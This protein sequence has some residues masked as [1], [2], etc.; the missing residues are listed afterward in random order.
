MMVGE[1]I[2]IIINFIIVSINSIFY[3]SFIDDDEIYNNPNFHSEEQNELGI[4]DG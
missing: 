4:S 1:I 3:F 2:A